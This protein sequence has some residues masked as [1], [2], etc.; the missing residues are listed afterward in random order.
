MNAVQ[1]GRDVAVA[2][3]DFRIPAD[4]VEVEMRQQPRAAPAAARGITAATSRSAKNL[5]MSAARSL[6][7][8]PSEP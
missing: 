2:Q 3:D 7:A 6:S 1:Q 4:D 5:L 8:P